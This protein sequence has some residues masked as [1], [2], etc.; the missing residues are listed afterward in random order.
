[1]EEISGVKS[2]QLAYLPENMTRNPPRM[3]PKAKEKH[4]KQGD[5]RAAISVPFLIA[6]R[7]SS[8][9]NTLYSVLPRA[10]LRQK[11]L[12]KTALL[13]QELAGRSP[14]DQEKEFNKLLQDSRFG[15]DYR[16]HTPAGLTTASKIVGDR[17]SDF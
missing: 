16:K 4:Q 2:R 8:H 1:M 17:R 15:D 7:V 11:R 10:G 13:V 5:Q 12:A 6:S 3:V 14:I 9:S